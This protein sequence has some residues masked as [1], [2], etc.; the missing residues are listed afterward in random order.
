M[1][2]IQ[3]E[4]FI[5]VLLGAGVVASIPMLL[6]ALG[7]TFA[8]QAG[9]L[10]L[11]IEGMMLMGAFGGFYVALNSNSITAG[12]VSGLAIGAV[13]GL[14]FGFLTISLRVDQV[15][16]G[17]GITILGAG[18][19]GFLFRDLYGRQF[20][21]LK[22]SLTKIAIPLLSDIPLIGPSLFNQQSVVYVALLLVPLFSFVLNRTRLGLQ[23]RAVGEN[24]F[25]A[26]AA[27]VNVYWVRYVAIII[28]GAMAGL[29]GAFLSV[30]DLNFFV[31]QMTLGQGF[32]AI[33]LAM[34]GRWQPPRV[35]VGALLFGLLR[36]LANGLQIIGVQVQPE[37]ILVLPYLGIIAAMILLAGRTSLPAALGVPYE[38]GSR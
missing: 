6:A 15:L 36:S 1:N 27:G 22:T 11:G 8:E 19:T 10:N 23:M 24:P 38:R 9:L 20:P 13:L 34:L 3:L 4:T 32:I 5:A 2:G 12:L 26:D 35:L 30:G 16:V 14:F 33:A 31:P 29:G 18:L 17:L 7:E 28:G 25:A 37:F 21:T